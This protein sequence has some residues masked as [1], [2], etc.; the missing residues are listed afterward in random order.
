MTTIIKN[1]KEGE[2][3]IQHS[4]QNQGNAIRQQSQHYHHM[5]QTDH[6]V[7]HAN[8]VQ[9]NANQVQANEQLKTLVELVT[10]EQKRQEDATAKLE[11][12]LNEVKEVL[13]ANKE[14]QFSNVQAIGTTPTQ[15]LDCIPSDDMT[16]GT[17]FTNLDTAQVSFSDSLITT[18]TNG[19]SYN[20][21]LQEKAVVEKENKSLSAHNASLGVQMKHKEEELKVLTSPTPLAKKL[22]TPSAKKL[23]VREQKAADLHIQ[24]TRN[25][26]IGDAQGR[27]GLDTRSD[28]VIHRRRSKRLVKSNP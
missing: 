13:F 18:T 28:L 22:A 24:N 25:R 8:Q 9:A 6:E 23:T 20:K 7:T 19:P 1:A 17:E 10:T 11:L 27:S 4:I 3:R 26:R 12:A 2:Q 14:N 15:Q 21:L 5:N 16:T